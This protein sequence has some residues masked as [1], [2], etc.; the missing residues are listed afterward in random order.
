MGN[1]KKVREQPKFSR[2]PSVTLRH[3]TTRAGGGAGVEFGEAADTQ[4]ELVEPCGK[5]T[6]TSAPGPVA[7]PVELK[8]KYRYLTPT[9]IEP[10]AMLHNRTEIPL[11]H[12]YI[13]NRD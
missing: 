12:P 10:G 4:D 13:P 2:V 11:W 9:G 8:I 7:V 3:V 1:Y 6:A 5:N